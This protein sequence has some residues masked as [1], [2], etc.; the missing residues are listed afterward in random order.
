MQLERW[1][2]KEGIPKATLKLGPDGRANYFKP[3]GDYY[4]KLLNKIIN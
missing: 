1:P 4:V 2:V 3:V